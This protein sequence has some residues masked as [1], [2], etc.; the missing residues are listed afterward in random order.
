MRN[1]SSSVSTACPANLRGLQEIPGSLTRYVRT[2]QLE[3]WSNWTRYT[4]LRKQNPLPHRHSNILPQDTNA[5]SSSK[6][7]AIPHATQSWGEKIHSLVASS[8]YFHKIRT[9]SRAPNAKRFNTLHKNW[10]PRNAL[11]QRHS[12]DSNALSSKYEIFEAYPQFVLQNLGLIQEIRCSLTKH[13]SRI[14]ELHFFEASEQSTHNWAH[15]MHSLS[16]TPTC[17]NK[18]RTKSWS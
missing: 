5:L 10:A 11:L 15:K 13:N 16:A 8:T 17:F 3:L 18:I 9:H 1:I 7:K 12:N 6:C 2:L 14:L 4:K